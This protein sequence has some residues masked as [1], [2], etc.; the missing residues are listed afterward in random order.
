MIVAIAVYLSIIS[1]GLLVTLA[2][3]MYGDFAMPTTPKKLYN[4]TK[5]NYPA[6][7]A[8]IILSYIFNPI[9]RI[10][11]F[12]TLFIEWLCHVGRKD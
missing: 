8:I 5:M 10:I 6:C 4:M 11:E 7:V 2:L 12:A 9:S 3:E 1:F